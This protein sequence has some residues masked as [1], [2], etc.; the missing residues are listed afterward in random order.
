[1]TAGRTNSNQLSRS[2]CT[3]PK[4]AE[5]ISL[6]YDNNIDLDPC[7]NEFSLINARIKY[8]LP[9]KDGL[10]ETWNYKNIFVNPPYGSDRERGTTIKDWLKKCQLSNQY[11][12]SEV[13]AL[14]PVATNTSH[15]KEYIF[16]KAIGI[17]FLYDTRLRF[18]I[19]GHLDEKGA[20]MSCAMVYWGTNIQKFVQIFSA[21][22]AA[23][24]LT[25]S[26]GKV[27]GLSTNYINSTS[28]F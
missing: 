18:Y 17:C 15:W 28:E 10:K 3:P 2:W 20:P 14:I 25:N 1:M 24:D 26:L 27:Y 23:L 4:Y 5:A 8:I 22:G 11:Y 9:E 7:S 16:S 12:K 13:L 21:F 19:N 6:F